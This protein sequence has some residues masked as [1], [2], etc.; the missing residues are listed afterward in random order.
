[1][2]GLEECRRLIEGSDKLSDQEIIQ[3]R[4][5]LCQLGELALEQYYQN[6]KSGK[7]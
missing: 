1:M 5:E 2:I 6:K 7:I 4:N 3:I